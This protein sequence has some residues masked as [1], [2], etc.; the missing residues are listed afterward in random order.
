MSHLGRATY[1]VHLILSQ[2]SQE[3]IKWT[4][5][6]EVIRVYC[7]HLN[8]VQAQLRNNSNAKKVKFNHAI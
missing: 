2:T 5:A 4:K 1:I 8:T 6:K 7:P 3:G